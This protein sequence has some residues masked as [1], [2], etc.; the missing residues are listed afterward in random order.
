MHACL[1][2][3]R[4]LSALAALAFLALAGRDLAAQCTTKWLPGLGVPGTYGTVSAMTSWDPDG[5]GPVAPQ[6]VAAG[7]FRFAG[8]VAADRIATWDGTGWSAIGGG[9]NDGITAVAV[10]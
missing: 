3:L 5:A 6:V 2:P 9:T 4:Y 1:A 10:R 7:F 8:N